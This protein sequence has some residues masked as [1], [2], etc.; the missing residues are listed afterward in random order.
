MSVAER[1]PRFLLEN[2]YLEKVLDFEADGR[3]VL[4]S[5]LGY[6]ITSRFVDHFLGR[7]FETPS[8]VLTEDMLR[9]ERQGLD[10]F[11]AGVDAI[12]ET[13]TRVAESYFADGS[14]EAACPPLKALL[15]LMVHGSHEGMSREDP[16]F[17][18]LFSREATLASDW[19]QSRLA[20]KQQRETALWQ[21]HLLALEGYRGTL[22][23]RDFD[24]ESRRR[25]A[26]ERLSHVASSA[27]LGELAGTI[28]ADP[29]HRQMADRRG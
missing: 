25:V 16:N 24:F 4:A 3:K 21:R 12:V 29:F 22:A 13:Q 10:D 19:Y 26:R 27:Y 5:R 23:S 14:V 6:R 9:P 15:N 8:G 18:K 1:Q 17:V 11:V 7:L 2:G 20:T 28:G